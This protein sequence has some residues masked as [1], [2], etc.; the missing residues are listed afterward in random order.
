[1]EIAAF[2]HY[3]RPGKDPVMGRSI[4]TLDWRYT[5]WT[6]RKSQQ[7][8]YELYDHRRDPHERNNLALDPSHSR[9]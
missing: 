2:S 9:F 1:M 3:L 6:P 7:V 4:R 8:E 5:E